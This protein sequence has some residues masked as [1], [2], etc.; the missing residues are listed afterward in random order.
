M[1]EHGAMALNVGMDDPFLDG[2]Q[3]MRRFLNRA[4]A[5]PD[6]ARV[7]VMIDSS[8][9]EII[10][11]GLTCMQG[12]AL[13]NS[14]SLK[15]GEAEC[16]RRARLIHR[17]GASA[18]VMLFDERGQASTYERKIE[19]AAR[20]YALL[21][22]DGF[23]PEDIVFDPNVLA[24]ATGVAEHDRCALDFI[25]ACAWIRA[26]CPAA[27][28]S[29]GVS[30]LSF[31]FRGNRAVR[32]AMHSVFLKHAA[33]AGLGL[34]I[35]NPA[36]MLPYDSLDPALREA[37]EDLILCRRPDAADR[38]LALAIQI[39]NEERG[40]GA[41]KPAS[42]GAAPA[43][44]SPE[45]RITQAII[46]GDDAHIEDDARELLR[47]YGEA[48]RRPL[49]IVEG[50]LMNGMREVGRLFGDGRLFLPQ[51]LG[52]ARVM[53]K[54]VAVLEPYIQENRD[55]R[56]ESRAGKKV[57]LATVKGDVHDIG[58]NLVGVVLGCNGFQVIDLGV[59]VPTEKI[60]QAAVA[61]QVDL[62]GLS[63]LITPSLD[64]MI[65]AVTAL[66]ARGVTIPVLIGGATTSLAHTA[67]R[68]A[69]EYSG[70]VIY[71]SDAS[72]VP[73]AAR[74]LVSADERPRFLE[75]TGE[76][77]RTAVARHE[78]I[79]AHTETVSLETARTNKVRI[80]WASYPL[81][82]PNTAGLISLNG[83]PLERV[84]PYISWEGF[85][86]AWELGGGAAARPAPDAA[87]RPGPDAPAQKDAREALLAAAG[88]MLDRIVAER[89]LE[90]RGVIG[91]FPAR[92]FNESIALY[93]GTAE[94]ARFIFPRNTVKKRHGAANPCLAD[95]IAP[96]GAGGPDTAVQDYLGLFA[97]SAG[98][99]LDTQTAA[100]RARGDD[101]GALLLAT[102]ANALTEA[103]S[104][105]AH[106]RVRREWWSYAPDE[107]S[108]TEAAPLKGENRGIRPAFGYPSCP[109]HGDKRRALRLLDAQARCGFSLTETAMLVPAASVC[110]MYF[111][112]PA[113]YY[114][115]VVNT[116]DLSAAR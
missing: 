94:L 36:T 83:Y 55:Q 14:I 41:E 29:A 103:F 31:S 38:L 49:D 52:S 10:E 53:K 115:S 4:L 113:S 62:I 82:V 23:P 68:I 19:I 114:F 33:G 56:A 100:L 34:A 116:R 73:M 102:L 13:V 25:R 111:A 61:E 24:V 92:S 110:G 105:E 9:W 3:A 81:P 50:P 71:V 75:Q 86:T 69:P 90:L 46:G 109:D 20:S 84:I 74:A 80:D 51:V 98:F 21:C 99:G 66:E 59:M 42:S 26:N 30:N 48:G 72:R 1:L 70:P 101:Y 28:I 7:P 64:E 27:Q 5:E 93:R 16:L 11:A 18:V 85:L 47:R 45:E 57:L 60:V 107:P 54:A 87:A 91:L 39:S 97:L 58:T 17:Y 76:A 95:F 35:V 78:Q 43:P 104:E 32:E 8:R 89:L 65:H 67:L 112:H 88:A 108:G 12:K 96:A 106:Q 37:A 44:L 22:A 15:E 2:P 6:I 40:A 79:A 77:Y 63:G